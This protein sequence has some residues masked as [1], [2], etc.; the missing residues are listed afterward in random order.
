MFQ[1]D[2]RD[3]NRDLADR[4]S[5]AAQAEFE[6]RSSHRL[7]TNPDSPTLRGRMWRGFENPHTSTW[8]L[9]FYYVTGFFI[10]L[11]VLTN[12]VETVSCGVRDPTSA[13][14]RSL[15]C[16]ERFDK[17]LF[18]LD[19]ACVIIF[20][21]EYLVRLYAAPNRLRQGLKP[22]PHQQQCR[23]NVVEF[24][25][26]N[27]SF[28]NVECCFDIVAGFGNIVERNFVLSTM[29]NQI[30]HVQFV[31]T[32]SKGQNFAMESF[33][34]VAVC[35]NKVERCFD[36]VAGVDGALFIW[37]TLLTYQELEGVQ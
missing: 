5:V 3:R 29:S 8:A 27:D 17:Q 12:I 7:I 9:V 11:S 6:L 15:R 32:L 34:I 14:N 25:K 2:Y 10:A 26:F 24:Y 35:G 30:E 28:N 37:L 20:T 13:E 31:S 21:A 22:R 4:L 1:E 23:S 19:T 33:D 18:C 36:N 16:G